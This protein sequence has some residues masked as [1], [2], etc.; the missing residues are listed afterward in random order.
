MLDFFNVDSLLTAEQRAIR[1]TVREFVDA[2]VLP[3]VRGWWD[4]HEFPLHMK[5]LRHNLPRA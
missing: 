3:D 1:Q 5:H 2:E 4:R